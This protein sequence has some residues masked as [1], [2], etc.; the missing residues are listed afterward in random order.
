MGRYSCRVIGHIGPVSTCLSINHQRR[1]VTC[2]IRHSNP[3]TNTTGPPLKPRGVRAQRRLR[4][5]PRTKDCPGWRNLLHPGRISRPLWQHRWARLV[6]PSGTTVRRRFIQ[7]P[8]GVVS[9]DDADGSDVDSPKNLRQKA[10]RCQAL[11]GARVFQVG[12]ARVRQGAVKHMAAAGVS[13]SPVATS[14]LGARQSAVKPM[15]A[16]SVAR[17]TGATRAL[18]DRLA[19]VKHM[20]FQAFQALLGARVLQVSTAGCDGALRSTWRQQSLRGARVRQGRSRGE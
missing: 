1:K 10:P 6:G 12:T 3:S 11:P 8:P 13:G 2:S 5:H 20:A 4:W 9:N 19:A 16:V 18:G 7:Q 17:S 15:A 14:A